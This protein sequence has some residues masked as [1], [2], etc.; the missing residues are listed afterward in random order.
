[1][2]KININLNLD[3]KNM[4]WSNEIKIGRKIFRANSY[5]AFDT[6]DF[7]GRWFEN[8]EK[9]VAFEV[10]LDSILNL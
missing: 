7:N 8:M 6:M 5:K 10:R 2:L 3:V 9:S 4:K 1:M